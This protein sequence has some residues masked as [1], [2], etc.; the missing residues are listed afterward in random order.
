[1][2]FDGGHPMW[3][4]L[5]GA[6]ASTSQPFVRSATKGVPRT[7]KRISDEG[8]QLIDGNVIPL[9]TYFECSPDMSCCLELYKLNP[10]PLQ[11]QKQEV[12]QK[13]LALP[14]CGHYKYENLNGKLTNM[15][16]RDGISGS[17]TGQRP[18]TKNTHTIANPSTP[19]EICM[20]CGPSQR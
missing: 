5:P 18:L 12:Y 4:T 7:A 1:M 20:L 2:S 15:R 6:S 11:A 3:T 16:K 8:Y 14:G 10:Y 17:W 13:I 9:R 19:E